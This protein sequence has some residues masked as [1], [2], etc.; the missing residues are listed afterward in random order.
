MTNH[1]P[2]L[3]DDFLAQIR[4]ANTQQLTET[5]FELLREFERRP[6]ADWIFSAW[7][8]SDIRQQRPDLTDDQCR[9]VLRNLKRKHDAN[10]GINW[11]VI[12]IVAGILY[13]EPKNLAEL[14]EAA[15]EAEE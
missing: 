15:A 1:T 10:L 11:E 13:P 2:I 12:D 3:N 5:L 7:H 9:K 4:A 6:D 8:I 14:R